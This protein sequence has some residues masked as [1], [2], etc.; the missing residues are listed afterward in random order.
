VIPAW[1]LHR[2]F[3]RL[4][5][6]LRAIPEA[7][8][9]PLARKRHDAA[10]ARGFPTFDGTRVLARNVALVLCWQ[11]KGIAPSFLDMLDHLVACGYAPLVVSNA[12]VSG[13]DRARLAPRIWR[14]VERPNFG[15]DF[16]GYRDGLWLLRSWG[17]RPDRLVILNDS[18]WFP[19]WPGDQTLQRAEAAP[20]DVTGTILRR[21]DETAFLESYFFS[22]RG[23]VLDHPGFR[24]F[25]DGLRLTSN[26]YKVIRRGERGFSAALT[27]AG[28]TIGPLF[29]DADF[30]TALA[31]SDEATLRKALH[32][33]ATVD[34]DLAGKGTSLAAALPGQGWASS[35]QSLIAA[36][37][38]KAQAYSS[39][40]VVAGQL[41]YP[42][43]KKSAEPV[44]AR[45]RAAFLR[46]V[47][48]GV[49]PAPLP[50]VL[51]EARARSG[52]VTS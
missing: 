13:A 36:V 20:F 41:G 1:K 2:E 3:Q 9:E 23:S 16:G 21:R 6:Q 15:Y 49:L 22:I 30:A 25:W 35:A 45:W 33:M 26:K 39:F 14:A 7:L 12:P 34:A 48:D 28:I 52:E 5:Q 47:D 27:A 11:P 29:P 43:L 17:V 8:W 40:P 46:A 44:S 37:L 32:Y 38:A 42:V 31:Q 24:A 10:L 51:L 18:I 4:G 50:A 19:I